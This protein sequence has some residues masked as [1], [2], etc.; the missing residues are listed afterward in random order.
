MLEIGA[1]TVAQVFDEISWRRRMIQIALRKSLRLTSR[2]PA[3]KAVE[4]RCA[5]ELYMDSRELRI[6]GGQSAWSWAGGS[7]VIGAR[8]RSS[9]PILL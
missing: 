9:T 5:A 3:R 2:S 6:G 4:Q 1:Q 8:L 7:S